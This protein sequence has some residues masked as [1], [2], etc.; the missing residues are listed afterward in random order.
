VWSDRLVGRLSIDAKIILLSRPTNSRRPNFFLGLATGAT[1]LHHLWAIHSIK[2]GE[3]M[4]STKYLLPSGPS[5]L[6]PHYVFRYILFMIKLLH[7]CFELLY[8]LLMPY[9]LGLCVLRRIYRQDYETLFHVVILSKHH[10]H[11]VFSVSTPPP[12]GVLTCNR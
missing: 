5:A 1:L 3:R 12:N 2:A 11:Y 6:S 7:K 4:D 8:S 10:H 9:R